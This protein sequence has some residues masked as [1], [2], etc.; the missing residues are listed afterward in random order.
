MKRESMSSA[1][2]PYL[3]ASSSTA[4]N[5]RYSVAPMLTI[6]TSFPGRRSAG[7]PSGIS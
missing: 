1:E 5:A 2:T 3:A 7:S 4:S 6:V